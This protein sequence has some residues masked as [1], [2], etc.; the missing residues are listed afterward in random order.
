MSYDPLPMSRTG[1]WHR[2]E[3][4]AGQGRYVVLLWWKTKNGIE[5]NE[6][7][8]YELVNVR[9][10]VSADYTPADFL[11]LVQA[12]RI[13]KVGNMDWKQCDAM[14]AAHRAARP[15]VDL[16]AIYDK[17]VGETKAISTLNMILQ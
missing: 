4:V 10:G 16:Q 15:K 8:H 7:A 14:L 9:T 11:A 13:T 6:V 17:M 2:D 5:T 3:F 12:G 1:I